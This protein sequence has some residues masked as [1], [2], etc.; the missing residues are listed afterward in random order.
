MTAGSFI[1]A[2][3]NQGADG[4]ANARSKLVFF[5]CRS[6]TYWPVP[7]T[8]RLV[9]KKAYSEEIREQLAGERDGGILHPGIKPRADGLA[10]EIQAGLLFLLWPVVTNRLVR[11]KDIP[12]YKWTTV[13]PFLFN[14]QQEN[15][16]PDKCHSTPPTV[17]SGSHLAARCSCAATQVDPSF[18]RKWIRVK[19]TS[20]PSD[21]AT[22]RT[23]ARIALP[24]RP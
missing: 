18:R 5:I 20:K 19:P 15:T 21:S 3:S 22:I 13:V 2:G 6:F 17:C 10:N 14:P 4:L 23:G 1:P 9:R 7:V 11:K 16:G 24:T 12:V 8:N